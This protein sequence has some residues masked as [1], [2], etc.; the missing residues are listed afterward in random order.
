MY[1]VVLSVYSCDNE[2]VYT[3][4]LS[5]GPEANAL[6]DTVNRKLGWQK[7][8]QVLETHE[9]DGPPIYDRSAASC[10]TEAVGKAM[11]KR[12]IQAFQDTV[13]ARQGNCTLCIRI[14]DPAERAR[15][16]A[17][18]TLEDPHRTRLSAL[19]ALLKALQQ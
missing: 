11:C 15:K 19:H 1:T 16:R 7:W 10:E 6:F 8:W 2:F 14:W 18:Q 3:E 9:D 12:D 4:H 13:A 17:Q 5:F